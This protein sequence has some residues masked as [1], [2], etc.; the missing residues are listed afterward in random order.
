MKLKEQLQDLADQENKWNLQRDQLDTLLNEMVES[1]GSPDAVLRDKLIYTTFSKLIKEDFLDQQQMEQLLKTCLD[2]LIFYNI[3]SKEDDSVLTRSFSS[4][5]L[6]Q[7]L[8]KDRTLLVLSKSSVSAAISSSIEYLI[9]EEDT[10]GYIEGKGWAHSIAHGADFLDEAIKHPYFSLD[11]TKSCLEAI[12]TCILN[13]SGVYID[14]EE[15]RLLYPV[16]ALLQKGMPERT[17]Y[18]W[19]QSIVDD[20]DLKAKEG[21]SLEYFRMKKNT[22]NFLKSLYFRLLSNNQTSETRALI[23]YSVTRWTA[24]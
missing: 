9:K 2:H 22:S 19:V 6:A 15:E 13:K 4:L 24:G 21:Y 20:H 10:R 14:D 3:C 12:R 7:L 5:V 8:S 11:K 17:L 16:E 23:E 18:D 1:I